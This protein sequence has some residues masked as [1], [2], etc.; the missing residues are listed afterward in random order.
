M[1]SGERNPAP[2][3]ARP[4]RRVVLAHHG[5]GTRNVRTATRRSGATRRWTILRPRE[6]P[7]STAWNARRAT[8][9]RTYPAV[10]SPPV[11]EA[12][13][14]GVPPNGPEGP[15]EVPLGSGGPVIPRKGRG[16]KVAFLLKEMINPYYRLLTIRNIS[17]S[18][19]RPGERRRL[20][21]LRRNQV[22][23]FSRNSIAFGIKRA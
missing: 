23:R 18:D 9:E 10:G 17:F 13:S 3:S 19:S 7:Q 11:H 1:G 20:Y 4:E 5:L 12:R 16:D 22:A 14:P 15:P 8:V 2:A 21:I 6:D